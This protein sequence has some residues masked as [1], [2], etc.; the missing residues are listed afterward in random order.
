[1][2]DR[3]PVRLFFKVRRNFGLGTALRVTFY[4]ARGLLFPALALPDPL[5]HD[6]ISRQVSILVS[7][8]EH[9]AGP[10]N[11]IV[12]FLAERA[13][14]GWELCVCAHDPMEPEVRRVLLQR[15]GTQPW[16]RIVSADEWVDD[17]TAVRWTVE[18]ATGRYV[19]L[20]APG[21]VPQAD[22]FARLMDRLDRDPRLEA[23]ILLASDGASGNAASGVQETDVRLL[24][25]RKP[26]YLAAFQ[27][28]WTLD[29]PSAA[30]SLRGLGLGIGCVSLTGGNSSG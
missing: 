28:H 24:L 22:A 17:A 3:S 5:A 16:I 23:A 9:G 8:A 25:Q 20:L 18:Q 12:D 10:L 2:I 6:T 11:A 19:A 1:M 14:F 27:G 29:A 7:A 4:R 15:R 26:G 13:R 21:Y 30:V